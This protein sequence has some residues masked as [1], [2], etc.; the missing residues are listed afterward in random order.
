M[1]TIFICYSDTD[2]ALVRQLADYLQSREIDYWLDLDRADDGT[3]L[4]VAREVAL[5]NS[6]MMLLVISPEAMADSEVDSQWRLYLSVGKP[7]VPL[8]VSPVDNLHFRL[9]NLSITSLEQHGFENACAMVEREI[10]LA[11]RE[12]DSPDPNRT[13]LER[14][15]SNLEPKGTAVVPKIDVEDID[16]ATTRINSQKIQDLPDPEHFFTEQMVLEITSY[17]DRDQ[18]LEIEVMPGKTYILGRSTPDY[19]PDVDLNILGAAGQGISRQHAKLT[20]ENNMLYIVDNNSTN[21]TFVEGRKL[22]PEDTTPLRSG[23]RIQ[24]GNFLMVI[25]YRPL[26]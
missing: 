12:M 20:L 6:D 18:H 16:K 4:A 7:I 14:P 15:M 3:T 19:V 24:M 21:F 1:T 11:I 9:A 17:K 23:D 8:M 13:I 10:R 25:R 2:E 5:A 22:T 26:D